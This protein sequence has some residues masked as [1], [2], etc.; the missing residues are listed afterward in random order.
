MHELGEEFNHVFGEVPLDTPQAHNVGH[1]ILFGPRIVPPTY[2]LSP[3][4][5]DEAM[6]YIQEYVEKGGIVPSYSP[7]EAPILFVPQK[8]KQ[9][10]MCVIYIALNLVT[11]KNFLYPRLITC[12]TSCKGAHVFSILN[13]V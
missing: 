13:L 1:I 4:E 3:L 8:N 11:A 2:R 9:L 6:H 7:F 10:R 5:F 12:L